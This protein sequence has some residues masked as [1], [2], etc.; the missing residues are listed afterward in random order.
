MEKTNPGQEKP[1]KIIEEYEKKF[2]EF[3]DIAAHDLDSPLRKLNSFIERLVL[4]Y[5]DQA[6]EQTQLYVQRIQSLVS[7]MRGM[8]D[9]L[10]EFARANNASAVNHSDCDLNDVIAAVKKEL[11]PGDEAMV[12]SSTGLPVVKGD[13][14][15]Y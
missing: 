1:E 9:D 11:D 12:V 3:I 7:D 4:K 2:R 13:N 15:Q 8:I 14:S 5:K 10:T 6:D